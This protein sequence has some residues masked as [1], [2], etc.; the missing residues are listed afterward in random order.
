MGWRGGGGMTTH[1]VG[2]PLVGRQLQAKPPRGF[3]SGTSSDDGLVIA[4]TLALPAGNGPPA[5]VVLLCPGR[6]DRDGDGGKARIGLGRALAT[7]LAARGWRPSASTA[8]A[9]SWRCWKNPVARQSPGV[10]PTPRCCAH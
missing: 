7:A 2:P 8:A 5:A 9:T 1:D 3:P 10:S 6:L 4:G